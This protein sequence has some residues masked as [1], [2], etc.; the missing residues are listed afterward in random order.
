MMILP[1]VPNYIPKSK[2]P[3]K[4]ETNV[5]KLEIIR[6]I[7]VCIVVFLQFSIFLHTFGILG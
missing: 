6:T 7:A 3:I 4:V 1:P 5:N 2:R